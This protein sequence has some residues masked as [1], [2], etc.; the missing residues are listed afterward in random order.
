M[1]KTLAPIIGI[2]FIVLNL[3]FCL[4]LSD[5]QWFNAACSSVII[6]INTLL[7]WRIDVIGLKDGFRISFDFI[8]PSIGVIEFFL[9]ACSESHFKDN[10]SLIIA[11]GLLAFQFIMLLIC[12][13]ISKGVK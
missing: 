8:M 3:L 11:I 6:I 7:V 2:I 1:K 5:Y 9:L 10:K 13:T 12:K 4:I